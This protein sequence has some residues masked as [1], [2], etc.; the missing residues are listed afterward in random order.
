MLMI[1]L[2][3]LFLFEPEKNLFIF[4]FDGGEA[5]RCGHRTTAAGEEEG[6]GGCTRK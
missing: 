1:L 6:G 5:S 4:C 3:F 2:F